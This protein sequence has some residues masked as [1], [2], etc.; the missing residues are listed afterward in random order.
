MPGQHDS[1]APSAA[2]PQTWADGPLAAFDIESTGTDVENDRI[3]TASVVTI[4]GA[5]PRVRSWLANPNVDIPAGATAVHGIT[6]EHAAAHGDDP[7]RVVAEIAHALTDAWSLGMPV[8]IYRAP[9]DLTM[10]DRE[11]RRYGYDGLMIGGLVINPLVLDKAL[12]P[13]RKGSRKL[14]DTARHYRITLTA[15]DAHT[16]TGD[17]LA[18]A[19]VAWKLTRAFP[20]IGA[21]STDELMAFQVE[22]ARQQAL[23]LQRHLARQ[24]KPEVIDPSWP[25]VP[26]SSPE[27]TA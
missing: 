26:F 13:Y 24:G 12:D 19:R 8:V 22:A 6:T 4:E 15:E 7:R 20:G 25:I 17:C 18:A 5:T 2:N 9:F 14:V 27:A 21:L 10:L 11:L 3:V 1:P 16:S 23:S